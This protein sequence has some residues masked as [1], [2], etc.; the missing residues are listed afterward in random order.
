MSTEDFIIDLFCRV[1]EAMPDV[2]RHSQANLYP[3]EVVTLAL[4]LRLKG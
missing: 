4:L 2:T 1:D 3:S